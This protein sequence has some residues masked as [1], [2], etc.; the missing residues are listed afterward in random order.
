M[1]EEKRNKKSTS[2]RKIKKTSNRHTSIFF[3][4]PKEQKMATL[5]RWLSRLSFLI[6]LMRVI[7]CGT[8]MMGETQRGGVVGN[9][10]K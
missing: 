7:V 1:S 6:S 4:P 5:W 3:Y 2:L 10:K 9:T 8:Y